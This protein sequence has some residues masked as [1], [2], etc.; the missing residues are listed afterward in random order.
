MFTFTLIGTIKRY[1]NIP[2]GIGMIVHD[3][4]VGT[5]RNGIRIG[6]RDC[7]WFV[8]V[9]N[10]KQ[11]DT[12]KNTYKLGSQVIIL[13]TGEVVPFDES[14]IEEDEVARQM[15]QRKPTCYKFKIDNIKFFNTYNPHA[16]KKLEK[17]NESLLGDS[18][19]IDTSGDYDF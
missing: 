9:Q 4:Q 17:H 1:V 3:T 8:C 6:D 19:P 11:A 14:D 18:K 12:I 15:M 10:A 2:Y 7:Q 5:E 13:G 16:N